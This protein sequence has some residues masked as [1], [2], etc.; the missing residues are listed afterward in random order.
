MTIRYKC[1]SCGSK[2]NIKDELAGTEGKCPKCKSAF[3]V[4]QLAAAG[5]PRASVRDV[6]RTESTSATELGSQRKLSAQE[7][8]TSES[9]KKKSTDDE[10]FDPV[11]FLMED[12]PQ[13]TPTRRSKPLSDD[14]M[15]LD[16]ELELSDDDPAPSKRPRRRVD[17]DS[18]AE[19]QLGS[20]SASAGAM[21]GG[22]GSSASAARDLLTRTVEE[23]RARSG[24]IEKDEPREPSVIKEVIGE[25]V[26]RGLP[27]LVAIAITCW[28]LYLLTM[29]TLSGFEYP[30]LGSVSGTVTLNGNPL[31]GARVEFV[32][33][34]KK[35]TLDGDKQIGA[36]SS[37]GFTNEE[38]YYELRYDQ[39]VEG[40]VV[41]EH[42]VRIN[43]PDGPRDLV[44]V[45][46]SGPI[47]T[48]GRTV[49]AGSQEFNFNLKSDN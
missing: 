11:A 36:R 33:V 1:D 19:M 17:L 9:P 35:V 15:P 46:Y 26:T 48:V 30:E 41:G 2:L 28:G 45:E 42:R 8:L 32:P 20:A 13:S 7:K 5:K 29:S 14:E 18:D 39:D 21:L 43:K 27:G 37:K 47:A 49:E 6:A 25:L 40:A 22:G 10:D 12:E 3:T 4:P 44:P 23:S 24:R 31:P 38:G 34:E 16:L